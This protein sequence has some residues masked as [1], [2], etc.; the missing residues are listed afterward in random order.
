MGKEQVDWYPVLIY[1]NCLKTTD[2]SLRL[3]WGFMFTG[4]G[5]FTQDSLRKRNQRHSLTII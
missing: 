3:T 4:D 5:H 2:V 1:S